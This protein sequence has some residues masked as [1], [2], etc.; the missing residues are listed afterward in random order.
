MFG[1]VGVDWDRQ[2]LGQ[3]SDYEL[4]DAL[5]VHRTTVREARLRRGI[6]RARAFDRYARTLDEWEVDTLGRVPDA[7]LAGARGCSVQAIAQQR[8]VR[9]LP[10]AKSLPSARPAYEMLPH[11]VPWTDMNDLF[12]HADHL[13]RAHRL[14]ITRHTRGWVPQPKRKPAEHAKRTVDL[15]H[16]DWSWSDGTIAYDLSVWPS[17][18]Q[19]ARKLRGAPPPTRSRVWVYAMRNADGRVKIGRSDNPHARAARIASA[20]GTS[21]ELLGCEPGGARRE[22]ELHLRYA[23]GRAVGEWF[24][25]TPEVLA[26]VS[27]LAPPS[28]PPGT[29][30]A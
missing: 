17:Y 8:R 18:I 16:V 19:R 24:D 21:I 7:V 29:P 2:P 30:L 14:G 9:G 25:A 27:T 10:P 6:R 15:E 1:V 22:R 12:G 23:A 5:G 26:W 3:L 4:A 13:H 20:A 28:E 11:W